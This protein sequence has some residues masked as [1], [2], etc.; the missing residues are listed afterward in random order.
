MVVAEAS[1][2]VGAV[3]HEVA[4]VAALLSNTHL[5][6]ACAVVTV[7]PMATTAPTVRNPRQGAVSA[8]WAP[9][10]TAPTAL[11]IRQLVPSER[12]SPK[13]PAQS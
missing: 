12:L 1:F 13:V 11:R 10:T 3:P 7:V 8:V 9:T 2:L 4:A 6:R 5:T